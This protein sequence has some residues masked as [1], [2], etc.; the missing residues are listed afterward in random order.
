METKVCTKCHL[1]KNVCDFYYRQDWKRHISICKLCDSKVRKEIYLLKRE[2]KKEKAKKHYYLNRDTKIQYGKNYYLQNKDDKKKYDEKYVISYKHIRS[3]NNKN[4]RDSINEKDR[5]RRANDPMYNI[6]CSV[7]SRLSRFLKSHNITKKNKTFDIVGCS[8]EFLKEHLENQFVE[9]M[10]WDNRKEWHIDHI[11]P[12][13]S[14]N[15]E[16]ELYKLCHY[17]N[18]QPLWAEDNLKKSNKIL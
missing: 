2:E 11:I 1:D 3:E 8:P 7:R 15:T 14:A 12:L 10:T 4:N 13:S 6:T 9:G 18:L 5:F 17:S 16:D